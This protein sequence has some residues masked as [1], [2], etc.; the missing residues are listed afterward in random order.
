MIIE[1][2][3]YR[4]KKSISYECKAFS[5]ELKI[6]FDIDTTWDDVNI[7]PKMF[8]MHSYDIHACH[9]SSQRNHSCLLTDCEN[10]MFSN[11]ENPRHCQWWRSVS[12]Y[13]KEV[14]ILSDEERQS[15]LDK[16]GI[17]SSIELGAAEVLVIK[18]GLAIPWN[19][20]RLLRRYVTTYSKGTNSNS[21]VFQVAQ[22]VP[23]LSGGRDAP[24]SS[25]GEEITGAPLV[26]IP[27]LVD[28]VVQLLDGNERLSWHKGFIPANEIGLKIGGDK[29]GGTFK[30]T[31]QIVNVATPNS[32]HNTCV[33]SCFATGDSVTNSC[34]T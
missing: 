7:H 8:C 22:I 11:A 16:A 4:A 1:L 10:A 17:S 26:F 2:T 20:L 15:L 23:H 18:A 25:G 29:G 27:H 9:Q 32:V 21:L 13:P 6:A 19:K 24:F 5:A 30:M 31:F 33:F 3:K 12:S 28:K 34:G 14:L